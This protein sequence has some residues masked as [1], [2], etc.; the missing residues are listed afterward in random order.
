MLVVFAAGAGCLFAPEIADHGYTSCERTDECAPG[1]HCEYGFCAPPTWWNE[2]YS[3]RYQILVENSDT[4]TVPSGA[5]GELLVGV[6]GDLSLDQVG[7]APVI[8]HEDPTA[9]EPAPATALRDPRGDNYAF[10]FQ[11]PGEIAPG[12]AFGDLWLYVGGSVDIATPGYSTSEEVYAAFESFDG[13]A[14]S[15][16]QYRWEGTADLGGGQLVM[17]ASSWLVSAQ[18][19]TNSEV[20]VD[21]QLYGAACAEFGLGL[22]ARY[23]PQSLDPPYAFFVANADGEIHSEVFSSSQS[24]VEIEGDRW[25]ADGFPHRFT[26]AVAGDAVVFSVDQVVTAEWQPENSLA[27]A[28]LY[29][30]MYTRD[31]DLR[32]ESWRAAPRSSTLP[33]ITLGERVIWIP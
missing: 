33:T 32:V 31:C 29:L 4:A 11:L 25:P 24:Q 12:A 1:R 8:V 26:I 17:R 22:A 27:D 16:E 6:D 19:F 18:T 13:D 3:A 15:A 10:V 23:T 9:T 2:Q 21:L 14:L 20:S 5:L 7:Y 30:H 28:E